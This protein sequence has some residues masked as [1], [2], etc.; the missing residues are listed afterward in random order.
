MRICLVVNAFPRENEMF[1]LNKVEALAARGHKVHVVCSS[2]LVKEDA[3]IKYNLSSAN[4][5]IH[6][7][8]VPVKLSDYIV[9]CITKPG[10]FF[11]SFSFNKKKFKSAYVLNYYVRFFNK[12]RCDLLHFEFP[13][14]PLNLFPALDKLPGRKI[15]SCREVTGKYFPGTDES[16]IRN[17]AIILNG[18]KLVHCVSND[19]R[20]SILPY[21]NNPDKAFVNY[22]GIDVQSYSITRSHDNRGGYQF[23]SFGKISSRNNY[24][25]SLYAIKLLIEQGYKIHWNIVG[26][27]SY[28]HELKK[29]ISKLNLQQNVIL[30]GKRDKE[31]VK[32]LSER[33]DIYLLP[34]T[35]NGFPYDVVE[36]M[37]MQLAV[38]S[39]QCSGISDIIESGKD[40]FVCADNDPRAIADTIIPLLN[41]NDL[42]KSIGI[43]AKAKVA[44]KFS[45]MNEIDI[46]EKLY[47]S[48]L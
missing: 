21:C 40:G 34:G 1:I 30:L 13:N 37:A 27:A 5:I 25:A 31:D 12:I 38:V 10:L 4:I 35:G 6:P 46:F 19:V 36:A 42:L 33:C 24:S 32:G 7:I 44:H 15:V 28:L 2:Y 17:W 23:L 8:S 39:T 45:L 26:E 3:F 41:N 14:I 20:N 48:I 9:D 11:K 18:V 29:E 16:E 22:P 47:R 43:A